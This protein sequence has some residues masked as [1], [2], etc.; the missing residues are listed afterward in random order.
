SSLAAPTIFIA[1][2]ISGNA[3]DPRVNLR[4]VSTNPNAQNAKV[5][6]EYDQNGV[7]KVSGLNQ[8]G[9]TSSVNHGLQVSFS[10][11]TDNINYATS[12]GTINTSNAKIEQVILQTEQD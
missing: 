10:G 7:F 2:N 8:Y 1:G 9:L 11:M 3:S 5:Q 4:H 12:S 6:C